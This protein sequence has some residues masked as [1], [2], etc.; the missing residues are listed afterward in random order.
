VANENRSGF[1][2]IYAGLLAFTADYHQQSSGDM[3]RSIEINLKLFYSYR[4]NALPMTA[5]PDIPQLRFAIQDRI[6]KLG[7]K[8]RTD[9]MLE[10][11]GM[12]KRWAIQKGLPTEPTHPTPYPAFEISDLDLSTIVGEGPVFKKY[13]RRW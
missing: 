2:V 5:I 1:D 8:Y 11:D 9:L 12:V 7:H 6:N 3:V 13:C 10:K 4:C